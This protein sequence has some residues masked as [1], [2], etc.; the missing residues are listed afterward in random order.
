M[1]KIVGYF[2]TLALTCAVAAGSICFQAG[3]VFAAHAAPGAGTVDSAIQ[4]AFATEGQPADIKSQ[5]RSA[6]EIKAF[7]QRYLDRKLSLSAM[8][9]AGSNYEITPPAQ[10]A[11]RRLGVASLTY[12]DEKTAVRRAALIY[13]KISYLR[14]TK[15]LTPVTV[16]QD[17]RVVRVFYTEQAGDPAMRRLLA[18]LAA[19]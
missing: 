1:K 4:S 13:G 6:S 9:Y 14:H 8:A 11:V 19:H 18:G 12:P 17:G 5:V 7:V 3:A 15:I 10:T 16:K 2:R